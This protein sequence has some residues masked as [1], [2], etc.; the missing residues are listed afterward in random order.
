MGLLTAKSR[1]TRA[2]AARPPHLERV[3]QAWHRRSEVKVLAPGDRGADLLARGAQARGEEKGQG[4]TARWS[5]E[6]AQSNR[7][8][9]RTGIPPRRDGGPP[10][11]SPA[12]GGVTAKSSIRTGG[13]CIN[14]ASTRQPFWALP[15]EICRLS[16][17]GLRVAGAALTGRQ[18][19]AEGI[20]GPRQARRVR[21]PNAER[22]GTREAA[23]H[24]I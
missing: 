4:G 12:T 24:R 16:R 5:P 15:W 8:G 10:G 14:P 20:L 21:H 17:K 6:E 2:R 1:G 13:C 9:R 22:R 23:P 18:K 19:S 11:T 7:A 3:C